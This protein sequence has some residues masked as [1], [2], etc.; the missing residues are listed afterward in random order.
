MTNT[1]ETTAAAPTAHAHQGH[2]VRQLWRTPRPTEGP[3]T[4]LFC[5]TCDARVE[6]A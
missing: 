6:G 4:Y 1:T 2:D 5:R 3:D